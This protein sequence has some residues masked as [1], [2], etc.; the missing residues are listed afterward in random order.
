MG[1]PGYSGSCKGPSIASY[2]GLA[3]MPE[4]GIQFLKYPDRPRKDRR[5]CLVE[6]TGIKAISVH[7]SGV[8]PFSV[9]VKVIHRWMTDVC[10]I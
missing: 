1:F 2:Q 6:G 10:D 8:I 3:R 7:L 4:L 5:S 9:D